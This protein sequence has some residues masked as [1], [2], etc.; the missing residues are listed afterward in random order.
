MGAPWMLRSR[1]RSRVGKPLRR[2]AGARRAARWLVRHASR[3]WA[4]CRRART[5]A[6]PATPRRCARPRTR[7]R[8]RH[9]PVRSGRVRASSAARTWSDRPIGSAV[10]VAPRDVHVGDGGE[11]LLLL[12]AREVGHDHRPIDP[13]ST[14]RPSPRWRPNPTRRTRRGASRPPPAGTTLPRGPTAAIDDPS[15]AS[16]AQR[17]PGP[18]PCTTRSR[19]TVPRRG[20]GPADRVAAVDGAPV[21]GA[22]VGGDGEHRG[23]ARAANSKPSRSSPPDDDAGSISG[24]SCS[25]A[26]TSSERGAGFGK[27]HEVTDSGRV[28]AARRCAAGVRDGARGW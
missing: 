8:G 3:P 17:A 1:G 11:R 5:R 24:V 18:S 20:V 12:L 7:P 23:P 10:A 16:V 4:R 26:C 13:P 25:R 6:R 22:G 21:G 27:A 2:R 9:D 28:R 19:S 15:G 14:T